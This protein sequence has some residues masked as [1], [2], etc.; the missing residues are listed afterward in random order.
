MRGKKGT[1]KEPRN[2]YRVTPV[3]IGIDQSYTNTG[4]TVC[5]DGKITY[6]TN[7]DFRKVKDKTP[8]RM[9]ISNK[10]NKLFDKLLTRYEP[11]QITVICERIR[12][13]T[14]S[15]ELRPQVIKPGAAMIAT[16]VDTSYLRGVK[17][18]SVDTR[19]WK[20]AIL[21]TSKPAT[22]PYEGVKDPKKI[23]EVKFLVER[24]YGPMIEAPNAKQ[25]RYD[26]DRADSACIALY[27][28]FGGPYNLL[29]EQ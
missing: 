12:T 26:D 29:L 14:A 3:V 13:F 15:D 10:L 23:Y 19:A 4:I 11:N 21:G 2:T 20:H 6:I 22:F 18:Y 7:L 24:G 1:Q 16:I 8:K 27:G 9:S 5:I 17:V 25:F 28:S